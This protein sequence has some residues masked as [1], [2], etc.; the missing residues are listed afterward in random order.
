MAA[1]AVEGK[2]GTKF[3]YGS[4]A[5]ILCKNKILT[6]EYMKDHMFELLNSVVCIT[7]MINRKFISFSA[8]QLY[9]LSYI[10]LH[11]STS[12]GMLRTHKVTISQM[13]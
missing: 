6:N 13:A 1:N 4:S 7:A 5:A 11:P 12:T 8:V 3:Q 2:H 10:H 9:D